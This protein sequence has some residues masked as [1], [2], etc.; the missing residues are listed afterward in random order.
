MVK[1]GGSTVTSDLLKIVN[2]ELDYWSKQAP[3]LTVGWW[4]ADPANPRKS[5]RE[6]Y[7]KLLEAL[8][9]LQVVGCNKECKN[10]VTNTLEL[11]KTTPALHD[12]GDGQIARTCAVLLEKVSFDRAN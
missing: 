6:H 11:W 10:V 2:E 4:N 9:Q 8:R 12:I 5:L 7:I 3:D 1:A